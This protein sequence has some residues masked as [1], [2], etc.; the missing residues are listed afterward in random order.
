MKEGEM[1]KARSVDSRARGSHGGHR[2][3]SI[4][5]YNSIY[6]WWGAAGFW[7]GRRRWWWWAGDGVLLLPVEARS[8]GCAIVAFRIEWSS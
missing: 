8:M 5:F 4:L 6:E 1:S 3:L 2:F 7:T